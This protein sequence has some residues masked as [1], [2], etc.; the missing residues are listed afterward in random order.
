MYITLY[1]FCMSKIIRAGKCFGPKQWQIL[2]I[3]NTIPCGLV[4]GVVSLCSHF[5]RGRAS[6]F[7]DE[8]SQE[9]VEG[10]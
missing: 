7:C 5:G 4:R 1:M 3:G 6:D 10:G 8:M 9:M 2:S